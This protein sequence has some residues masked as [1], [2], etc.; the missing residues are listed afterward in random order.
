M[1]EDNEKFI[2]FVIFMNSYKYKVLSFEL[3]NDSTSWQYYMNDLLF[4]YL[5][6]FCQMYLNDILIYSKLIK[7]HIDHVRVILKKL[8]KT[9]L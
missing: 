5:N 3:T 7:K 8:K 4:N 9:N 1:N 2:T 6:N